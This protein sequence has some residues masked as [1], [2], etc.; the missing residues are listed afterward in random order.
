[1][2]KPNFLLVPLVLLGG[3]GVTLLF[4]SGR[5]REMLET[6]FETTKELQNELREVK[7][8]LT[9]TRGGVKHA[10]NAA[11]SAMNASLTDD[12]VD[13]QVVDQNQQ[14]VAAAFENLTDQINEQFQTFD[15]R[16]TYLEAGMGQWADF[17][18]EAMMEGRIKADEEAVAMFKQQVLDGNLSEGDRLRALRLLRSND[19]RTPE[20]VKSMMDL[21][22][23]S[24]NARVRADIFR[25]LDGVTDP[26]LGSTLVEF[27]TNDQSEN[28]RE[29][30]AEA[31]SS[32]A[33]DPT[34]RELLTHIAEQDPSKDVREEA[35]ESIEDFD[36]DLARQRD[37]R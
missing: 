26:A 20:V 21:V 25:Q 33:G 5:D 36:R 24:D 10:Q 29:E 15:E 1:M 34:I 2:N 7:R 3:A 14:E 28:V 8:E 32:F 27:V 17:R 11:R 23:T 9:E 16:M 12:G 6:A 30:A 22:R 18:Q 35:L 31:L 4:Q 13:K 19:A 37:G